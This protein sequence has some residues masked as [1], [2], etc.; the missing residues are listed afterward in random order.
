M[1]LLEIA[2]LC[3]VMHARALLC[4]ALWSATAAYATTRRQAVILSAAATTS[5]LTPQQA[6]G[7]AAKL[8]DLS[9]EERDALDLASRTAEGR[10]LRSGVRVI[11]ML[12]VEPR[13][14][15]PAVGERTYVH[16]KV[17]TDGFRKGPPVE[18]SFANTRPYD[19]II[20]Q[21]DSRFRKGFDEGLQG[22][23]E[24]DWRRLV[25]PA[26]LACICAPASESRMAW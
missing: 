21:P 10:L 3:E 18:S 17:W 1:R 7:A 13:R 8:T 26:A 5:Y 15:V 4:A 23:G 19:Y 20:G 25:V 2:I 11:D 6:H 9:A 12:T 14:R 16:F 22:M 24:G